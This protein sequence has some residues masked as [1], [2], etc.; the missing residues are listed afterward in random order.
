MTQ[1]QA[2]SFA[3]PKEKLVLQPSPD[4]IVL[5]SQCGRQ[6]V[7]QR[8]LSDGRVQSSYVGFKGECWRCREEKR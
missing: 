1:Q 3:K 5:C 7:T 4:V 2:F 6:I 8:K